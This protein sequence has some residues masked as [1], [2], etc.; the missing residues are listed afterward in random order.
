[1]VK[2]IMLVLTMLVLGVMASATAFAV[3]TDTGFKRSFG[4]PRTC[5]VL[6]A[7]ADMKTEDF[8]NA[9]DD[10]LNCL[11]TRKKIKVGTEMQT[12]YQEYWLNKG[13]LEEG[14]LTLE[15]MKEFVKMSGYDQCLF[16]VT[17]TNVEKSKVPGGWFTI[18]EKTRA[19]VEV[20]GFLTDAH[21]VLK[22]INITKNDD[23][24]HSDLRAKRGAFEKCVNDLGKQ[25]NNYLVTGK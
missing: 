2:K 12:K 4:K 6:I 23:S 17:T 16:L 11:E 7:P 9:V 22:I 21:K 15:V 14:K 19:S 10:S 20:R 3:D 24:N 8:M 25:F 1:M 18:I 5:A 13:E